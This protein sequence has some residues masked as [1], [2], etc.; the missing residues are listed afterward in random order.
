[1]KPF[2]CPLTQNTALKKLTPQNSA[3]NIGLLIPGIGINYGESLPIIAQSPIFQRHCLFSGFN[4][5]RLNEN[6]YP[7][8]FEN[9]L[10][11]QKFAYVVNCTAASLLRSKNIRPDIVVG[12]SMGIYA[13]LFAAGYFSFET[14]LGIVEKAFDIVENVC[15]RSGKQFGMGIILGLTWK[16]VEELVIKDDSV[17]ISV[18]NGPHNFVISGLKQ[19]VQNALKRATLAGA[20][21]TKE[22]ESRH[23][24][25][26][27]L[28]EDVADALYRY[29][30]TI[31]ISEPETMVLS[32]IDGTPMSPENF[33]MI[34][35][36]SLFTPLRFDHLVE[37]LYHQHNI[38]LCYDT[39]PES[40]MKKLVRYVNRKI[41]IYPLEK[42]LAQ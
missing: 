3:G 41:R 33:A 8:V 11:S 14:G 21:R 13:A 4:I 34:I 16:N 20:I 38:S 12:Y 18:Y 17:H 6:H 9:S 30:Q 32:P 10:W 15:R 24:Y 40:S 7:L 28:I 35:T 1:M 23:P 37:K 5:D 25:H 27:K 42:A 19:E 22:I 2:Q 26:C 31:E 39:G 36:R 29:L